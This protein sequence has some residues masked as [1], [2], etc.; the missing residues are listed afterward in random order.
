MSNKGYKS[1]RLEFGFGFKINSRM[2][3]D[4]STWPD[5]KTDAMAQFFATEG[6][7]P[8]ERGVHIV[9]RW[10]NPDNKNPRHVNWKTTDDSGQSLEDFYST[11]HG[12]R[13][14]LRQAQMQAS[15]RRR[16]IA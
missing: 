13:G 7:G 6:R 15:P 4:R 12:A 16:R 11:L 3:P 8:F 1:E 5:L 14:A 9:A 2:H 10:R